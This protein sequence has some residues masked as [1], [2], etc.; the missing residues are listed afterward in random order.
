V[1][2]A[3]A[4]SGLGPAHFSLWRCRLY[5]SNFDRAWM[6]VIAMLAESAALLFL[7]ASILASIGRSQRRGTGHTES[8]VV[9]ELQS[10]VGA[11]MLAFI[12]VQLSSLA[13]K[14]YAVQELI[15][16]LVLVAIVVAI[17]TAFLAMAVLLQE[18][19]RSGIRWAKRTTHRPDVLGNLPSSTIYPRPPRQKIA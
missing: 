13:T 10:R 5:P 15:A 18:A 14:L 19:G 2:A 11:N 3:R 16:A 7:S 4:R 1:K 8:R 6:I 9:T 17:L 12:P